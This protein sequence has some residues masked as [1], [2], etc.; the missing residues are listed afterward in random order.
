MVDICGWIDCAVTI[1]GY[2]FAADVAGYTFVATVGPDVFT[3]FWD[4]TGVII[5]IVYLHPFK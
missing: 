5:Y 2:T 4:S 3:G 1:T